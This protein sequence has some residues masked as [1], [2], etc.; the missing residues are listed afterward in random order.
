[1]R[2]T[3]L[4]SPDQ[5]V[6]LV[7]EWNRLAG[8]VPFRTWAWLGSWWEH[9]GSGRQLAVL[10]AHDGDGRLRGIVPWYLE[11]AGPAGTSLHWLGAG[12]VCTDYLG[13]LCASEDAAAVAEAVAE[14]LVASN[15]ISWDLL[16]LEGVTA[17]EPTIVHLVA[18]A[19]Q[20][21]ITV[22]ERPGLNTWR[23]PLPSSWE[24]YVE[25]L[26]KS[27]RKQVRRV[28]RRLVETGEAVLHVARSSDELERGLSILIDLH[29]RRRASL[30]QPGCFADPRF[31]GFVRAAASRLL[32]LD[33][34][35]LAWIELAG[36]PAAVEFQVAGGGITYAYQA[37]V[38][39]ELLDEEPGRIIN[40]ATLKHAIGEGQR[41][42]DFLRGDE[43]Y[44]A[45][46]RAERQPSL[47]LRL[48]PRRAA[49]QLR[50]GLWLAGDTMKQWIKSGLHLSGTP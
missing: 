48:V 9:Y 40:I 34:L 12:E 30:G 47:E 15:E 7:A 49:A 14:W 6:P 27:H 4:S 5:I 38:E 28:D 46:W 36:R 3:R 35:R 8:G 31:E 22:H 1:M 37:G 10:V 11:T 44:K 18:S 2:I 16:H 39:P 50:H 41:G 33:M 21:G 29:Q 17:G 45:H 43:P 25:S 13:L 23:I 32:E 20:R 26:S 24:A 19:T 42:F